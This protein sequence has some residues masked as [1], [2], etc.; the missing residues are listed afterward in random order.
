MR[1]LVDL[2][3]LER[4]FALSL[5][6]QSILGRVLGHQPHQCLAHL[7]RI[8]GVALLRGDHRS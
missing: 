8:E 5:V 1:E 4:H 3:L 6:E 2:R 7:L